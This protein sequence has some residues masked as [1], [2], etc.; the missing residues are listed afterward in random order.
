MLAPAGSLE[1]VE[2]VLSAGAD[3]VY[4]GARGWSREGR[5]AGLS[6]DNA[7][8]AAPLCRRAGAPFQVAFNTI[9][10]QSELPAFLAAI[11]QFLEAGADAVI[12]NDPGVIA[13][14]RR[15]FPSPGICASVGVSTLNPEDALFYREIGADTVVLPTAVAHGEI[16]AIK[17]KSGL[18]VEVFLTCRAEVILQG[19]CG[20][21]GYARDADAPPERPGLSKAGPASSAKRG[22][23]CFLACRGFAAGREPHSIEDDLVPWILAGTDAFKVQGRD[24]APPKISALIGRLRARLDAAIRDAQASSRRLR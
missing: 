20:L 2:A 5:N 22:G 24:L 11:G 1:A 3:A 19:K 15:E 16:P 9:P 4:A 6:P 12:L 10:G 21:S 14:V 23:R 17:A 8:R 13:L 7:R 18:S